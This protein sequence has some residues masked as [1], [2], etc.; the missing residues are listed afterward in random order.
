ML[1]LFRA[2]GIPVVDLQGCLRE[3]GKTD[4]ELYAELHPT[5]LGNE[6]LARCLVRDLKTIGLLKERSAAGPANQ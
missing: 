5:P 3:S 2:H 1:S 6:I 4:R